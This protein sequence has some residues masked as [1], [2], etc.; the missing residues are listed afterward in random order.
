MAGPLRY[1]SATDGFAIAIADINEESSRMKSK[2]EIEALGAD[3][4][5]LTADLTQMEDVQK[6]IERQLN[7]VSCSVLVNNAG[8]VI[9]TPPV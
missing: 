7:G 1:A 2:R 9:I 5:A 3:V 4:L 8:R 6:V